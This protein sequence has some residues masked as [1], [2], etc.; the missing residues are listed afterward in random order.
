MTKNSF[1]LMELG[2]AYLMI[3]V[4]PINDFVMRS[5][6]FKVDTG[7]DVSTIH[8]EEL[9]SLG[10]DM[11]WISRNVVIFK[12]DEKPVTA[13]GDRIDAGYVRLPLINILGYEGK[14]W[15][16]QIILDDYKDFRNLLGR[17]LLNGFNYSFD[18]DDDKFIIT[19]A[20]VFKQRYK[21]LPG[22]EVN[23]VLS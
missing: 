1:P 7:A 5:V 22:Q 11:D 18:N 13:S 19:R 8:K 16:F 9:F 4:K 6:Q 17:D 10:Y 2:R 21:F 14:S 20:K 3:D 15:P 12:D 23:D